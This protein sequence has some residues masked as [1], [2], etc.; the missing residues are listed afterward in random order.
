MQSID[1]FSD[2]QKNRYQYATDVA[3]EEGHDEI[4]EQD[5][6]EGFRRLIDAAIKAN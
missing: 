5:E 3:K 4:T 6:I 2:V 1:F